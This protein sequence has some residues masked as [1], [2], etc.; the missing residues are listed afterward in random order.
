M[1]D[2]VQ[3]K[4]R[5]GTKDRVLRLG[6]TWGGSFRLRIGRRGGTGGTGGGGGEGWFCEAIKEGSG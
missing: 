6:K 2:T 4:G 3:Q 5:S 1:M